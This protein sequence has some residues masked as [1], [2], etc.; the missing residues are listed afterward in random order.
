LLTGKLNFSKENNLRPFFNPLVISEAE[1]ALNRTVNMFAVIMISLYLERIQTCPW[2][3]DFTIILDQL[4][5][6]LRTQKGLSKGHDLLTSKGRRRK[7]VQ[8][9]FGSK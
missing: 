6:L 1:K 2:G 9:Y 4:K 8:K 7:K 5:A 3:R